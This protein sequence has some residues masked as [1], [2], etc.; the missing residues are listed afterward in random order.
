MMFGRGKIL[1]SSFMEEK[2]LAAV[3]SV[4]AATALTAFKLLVGLLTGSLGI[5]SEALHSALD[6]IAAAMT[7]FA[8]KISDKPADKDH[9][10]GHGKVENLSA[11]VEAGLLLLTCVWVVWEAI[12]RLVSGETGF[13]INFWAFAVVITSIL[14]DFFRSRHL[15]KVAKKYN[16]QALEADALHFSTDILSSAVVLVGLISAAFGYTQADSIAA[17]G[18][19]VIVAYVSGKLAIKA[20][21]ALIDTAPKGLADEIDSIIKHTGG[22]VRWHDLRVRSNGAEYDV[23]VNIHVKRTLSIVE[24]H[25][26]SEKIEHKIRK[27]LGK[28]TISVH[29]EPDE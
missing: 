11:L 29:I 20:V 19:S 4:V 13:E 7:W 8:V 28:G 10:F 22:V 9:M 2:N 25:E 24:A 26:I 1:S 15:M 12:D 6:L 21:N 23:N 3:L 27:K 18:V 5:L 16:S 17:L 14:V